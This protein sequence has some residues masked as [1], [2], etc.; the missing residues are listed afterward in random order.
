MMGLIT[1][2]NAQSH[3]AGGGQMNVTILGAGAMGSAMA[4]RLSDRDQ[5]PVS[6]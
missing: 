4:Y 5:E 6:H 3:G 1:M 2:E